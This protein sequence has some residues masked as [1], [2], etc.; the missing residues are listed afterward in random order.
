MLYPTDELLGENEVFVCSMKSESS[1][2]SELLQHVYVGLLESRAEGLASL[3]VL[4]GTVT[5]YCTVHRSRC[6]YST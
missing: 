2:A 5:R 4:Y 6:S 3:S 1:F